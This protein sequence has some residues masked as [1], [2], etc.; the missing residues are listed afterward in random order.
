M[1][2][3][4]DPVLIGFGSNVGD[5][6]SWLR[7]ARRRVAALPAT[8][9]VRAS[10]VFEPEPVGGPPQGR[11]LNACAVVETSLEPHAL[12]AA[13]LAVESEAGRVPGEPNAPRTLDLDVL[14]FAERELEDARLV[15]PHPRFRERAF[16]LVP[17]A[18]I[19]GPW[20]VPPGREDVTALAARVPAA[21][22][23]RVLG[24]EGWA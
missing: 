9:L 13:L 3:S 10:S 22:V 14:L 2:T 11:Y 17:A 24:A 4:S 7:F 19:A 21:G 1:R 15:V 12:L 5:R 6:L 8:R 23:A 18:E 16:A 20:R